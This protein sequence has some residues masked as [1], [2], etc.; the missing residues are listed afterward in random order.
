MK[1]KMISFFLLF[2]SGCSSVEVNDYQNEKPTL[3]LEEYL[4]GKIEAHGIFQDRSGLI[5]KRFHVDMVATWSKEGVGVLEE[6]FTYS[7]GTTSRRVWTLK[8]NGKNRYIGTASDVIGE[9]HGEVAGNA[10]RWK[11]TLAL[12]VDG[13]TY[14]VYFDDWMYLMNDQVMLNKSKMSKFGFYLGEVTLTF[15]K[16]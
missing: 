13:K 12:P 8:P 10:F 14:H 9:A 11:Y 4:N 7:D 3:K 15:I 1:L 6:D 16:R 5:V 2:L